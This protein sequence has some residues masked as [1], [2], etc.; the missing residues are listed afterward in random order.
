MMVIDLTVDMM[1]V[2]VMTVLCYAGVDVDDTPPFTFPRHV[3]NRDFLSPYEE[4]HS[5]GVVSPTLASQAAYHS[6][7]ARNLTPLHSSTSKGLSNHCQ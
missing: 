1:A 3:H 4:I 7:S 5:P 2:V 6:S